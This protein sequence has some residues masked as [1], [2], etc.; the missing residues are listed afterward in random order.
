MSS[1]DR[2]EHLRL[3]H[4]LDGNLEEVSIE[5]DEIG[6]PAGLDGTRSIGRARC[7]GA[8]GGHT[9]LGEAGNIVGMDEFCV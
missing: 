7:G 4:L 9:Q 5:H 1:D 6:D 2:L 8:L 3:A